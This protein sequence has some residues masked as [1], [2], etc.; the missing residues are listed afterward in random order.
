MDVLDDNIE[1]IGE[2]DNEPIYPL[3]GLKGVFIAAVIC[4]GVYAVITVIQIISQLELID[5]LTLM[6]NSANFNPEEFQNEAQKSN[7][8]GLGTLIW[9]AGIVCYC[10]WF[11][12]ALSNAKAAGA[13]LKYSPSW[14][15]GAIFV[16]FVNLYVPFVA[17]KELL[18]SSYIYQEQNKFLTWKE[19]AVNPAFYAYW[20]IGVLQTA[21]S[22]V[23]LYLITKALMSVAIATEQ[24]NPEL[25][26]SSMKSYLSH[27]KTMIYV[28]IGF[29]IT[30]P[31]F[32]YCMYLVTKR[33]GEI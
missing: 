9:I 23:L 16:P 18:Q 6:A 11:Y 20:I 32:S 4:Y 30:V 12:R 22:L 2:E 7:A 31:L 25:A 3:H 24:D 1:N 19:K 17:L 27:L 33:Q 21:I 26:L 13:D 8:T 14:S 15:V 29:I 5:N 10:V 28:S